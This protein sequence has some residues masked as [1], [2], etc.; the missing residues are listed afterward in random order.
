MDF[1]KHIIE[2]WLGDAWAVAIYHWWRSLVVPL[3]HQLLTN[4]KSKDKTWMGIAVLISI[5][6]SLHYAS[7]SIQSL[8]EPKKDLVFYFSICNLNIRG[9]WHEVTCSIWDILLVRKLS[10]VPSKGGCDK[11]RNKSFC[12]SVI[13]QL[14]SDESQ[15][16]F[17]TITKPK[18]LSEFSM[19]KHTH[20]HCRSILHQ[21]SSWCLPPCASESCVKPAVA[22]WSGCCELCLPFWWD[23]DLHHSL[24][25]M[26]STPTCSLSP[27]SH[28]KAPYI[29]MKWPGH[30]FLGTCWPVFLCCYLHVVWHAS[31]S[32]NFLFILLKIFM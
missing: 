15:L 27:W 24:L 13:S 7:C 22:E 14:L 6:W 29:P 8:K 5:Y 25:S 10:F 32:I 16:N 30:K 1:F 31:T 17:G 23:W 18:E 21:P 3:D 19:I 11:E 2:G 12:L 20:R 9:W 28:L 4:P 26:S